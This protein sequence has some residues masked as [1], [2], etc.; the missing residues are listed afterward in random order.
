MDEFYQII[1]INIIK[2]EE[3]EKTQTEDTQEEV[4]INVIDNINI[5]IESIE[6]T[7]LNN[8]ISNNDNDSSESSHNGEI[9]SSPIKLNIIEKEPAIIEDTQHY[10]T[11]VPCFHWKVTE[12]AISNLDMKYL[13]GTNIITFGNDSVITIPFEY[14]SDIKYKKIVRDNCKSMLGLKNKDILTIKHINNQDNYHNYL[15]LLNRSKKLVDKF[16]NTLNCVSKTDYLWR[17]Y[18]GIYTP[19]KINPSKSEVYS[20]LSKDKY[21]DSSLKMNNRFID[22]RTI[23]SSISYVIGEDVY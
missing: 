21:I 10:I 7:S 17:T 18:F 1:R 5:E 13:I 4:P 20:D 11:I 9:I 6:E 3:N 2:T 19:S 23:Y 22:L 14:S 8:D 12:S 16:K 15:I